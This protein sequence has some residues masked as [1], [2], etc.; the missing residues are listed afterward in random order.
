[1]TQE[2]LARFKEILLNRKKKVEEEIEQILK[3]LD[4]LIT[5]DAL[6]DIEDLAQIETIEDSDKAL[7]AHL[8]Q[9]RKAIE[10][11]LKRIEEGTY[12]RCKDGSEIPLQKLQADPLY[13]C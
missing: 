3:E 9:E 1:M 6:D 4:E 5:Y 7:L 11:A 12:G 10:K 8:L 13:E 2:Q